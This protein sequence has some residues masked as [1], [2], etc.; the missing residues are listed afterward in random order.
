MKNTLTLTKQKNL[1]NMTTLTTEN[2]PTNAKDIGHPEI[3]VSRDH[4]W[5][6]SHVDSV[7]ALKLNRVLND[8]AHDHLQYAVGGLLDRVNASPIYLHINSGGGSV[9]DGLAIADTIIRIV[10]KGVPVITIVEGYAASAA[11]LFSVVGSARLIH[12]N[13]YMLVHQ[14]SS[15]AW[16]NFEQLKDN[17]ENNERL[18]AHIKN[19]YKKYTKIPEAE[20]DEVLKHDIFWEAKKCK[21][22]GLVD[23]II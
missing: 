14:L 22:Y 20:I 2:M 11:T 23:D 16:G 19:I 17:H 9:Y 4:V 18:M 7:S 5:F 6:Y 15:A 1:I 21:K 13:S 8:L 12:E 3:E 10:K